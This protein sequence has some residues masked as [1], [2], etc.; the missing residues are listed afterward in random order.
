M[1]FVVEKGV[2]INELNKQ[3]EKEN[4]EQDVGFFESALA[5]VATGLW[6]I[7]K[8]VVSLGAEIFDLVG[9]TNTAKDVE[10]WFDEVNPFDDEA[11]AR[12][13]GKITQALTQ[14]APLAISGAA[15]G[16]RAGVKGAS[17][18]T[19]RAA[20]LR[21]AEF[22]KLT[23]STASIVAKKAIAAKKA[24]KYF[25]LTNAGRKIMGP[26]SGGIVGS[27]V[28]EALVADEDIGTLADIAKGTSF[29]PYALTM[30]DRETKE[31][32]DEAYRKLKNRLKFG[33]EGALFNLA[34]FGA[35][36][37]VQKLRTPAKEGVD[38]YLKT[39]V[40]G[41]FQKIGLG[42][43]AQG[44]GSRKTF[45]L[46]KGSQ[47]SIQ[48]LEIGTMEAIKKIDD[49]AKEVVPAIDDF[50]RQS[51]VNKEVTPFT[52][53][54]FLSKI[55]NILTTKIDPSF[56]GPKTE[57]PSLGSSLLKP[58]SAQKALG[59]IKSRKVIQQSLSEL[60]EVQNKLKLI[61]NE[62]GELNL[63]GKDPY[64]RLL[65]Q[66]RRA[67]LLQD[68]AKLSLREKN[69][70][71]I[72]KE[73]TFLK[74]SVFKIDDYKVSRELQELLDQAKKAGIKNTEPLKNAIL[75]MRMGVD[76]VSS[77]LMQTG[78]LSGDDFKMFS[79]RLGS[80]LN[81][82]YAAFTKMPIF[83]KYKV[84]DE[85]RQKSFD[86]LKA[87]KLKTYAL[88]EKNYYA[89]GPNK[90]QLISPTA[91]QVKGTQ[92]SD[93]FINKQIDDYL[94]KEGLDE[95]NVLNKEFKNGV[96][97]VTGRPATLEERKAVSLNP[98]ILEPKIAEP[99][100]KELIGQIK[101]PKYTFHSTISKQAHLLYGTKYLDD[102]N[103]AWSVGPN[104]KI[105]TADELTK[106]GIDINKLDPRDWKY[107]E[108]GQGRLAGI[109]A[110]DGKYIRAPEYDA[111]FD[112]TSDWLNKTDVGTA[113]R[114]MLLVPK[115]MS[116]ISKTILS[117]ITH[118]RNFI[119]AAS[120]A[121]ANGA[122]LPNLTDI[123]TLAPK[124]FG[125][126]GVLGEAYD[127]TAKRV[128]GTLNKQQ[129]RSYQRLKELGLTGTQVEAGETL[130]LAQDIAEGATGAKAF[131]KL[132]RA[133]KSLKKAYIKAQDTYVAED[134][135]W[136]IVSF[137]LERNR[138]NNIFNKIGFTKDNY[139][140]L[141]NE[142]SNVGRYFRKKVT[143]M[144]IVNESYDGFLDELSA[145]MVRNQ[146]PNYEYIGRTA[147]ALRQSPFGNF[148]A[149]PI[150]IMRTGNNII[151]QSIDEITSG[152][153]QL[154]ALGTRRLLSFG[155]TVGGIPIALTE[156][157][158]AKNN[159]T[160]EEMS[161]LRKF[162][163]E[164]SKNS[165]LLPVGR[166]E[167]G[168]L[169]YVDLSYSTAYDFLLRPYTT[170]VNAIAQTD[171]T[172]ESLKQA[173]GEGLSEGVVEL[174]EPFVSESIFTEALVDSTIRRGIG[175]GGRRVWN[176]QDDPMVKIGKGIFH[177]G[178]ALT[179]G[180]TSQLKRLGL[181][182]TGKTS[183]YGELYNLA[184]E[185]PGLAGFRTINSN[186]ERALTYMST[187]FGRD[188]KKASNL[189]TGPLLRGGRV[190]PDDIVN[191]Y[192][193]SEAQRFQVLKDMYKNIDAA[194]TLGVSESAIRKKVKRK[195]L[196]KNVFNQLMQGK[197]TPSRPNS[198]FVKRMSEITR[199]LNEKEGVN[200]PNPYFES[201]PA[202]NDIISENRNIGLLKDNVSFYE[203]AQEIPQ[204]QSQLP[205]VQA[206]PLRTPMPAPISPVSQQ[207]QSTQANTYASLF[208]R[209]ELGNL[210]AQKK[211]I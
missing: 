203:E 35:G 96:E 78:K 51:S 115:A 114:Y 13:V 26:I 90:G 179:P 72:V 194:R 11:E 34:L 171:G 108:P 155:T 54:K 17:A 209:D 92:Y 180:S 81:D 144:D 127:L 103:K 133:P 24:G 4:K 41:F 106:Q 68:R 39:P 59:Q 137:E 105:F 165:T 104:K 42:L 64:Q 117:P 83:K 29:E 200:L 145:N 9:D 119:S 40:G 202:I 140:T 20:A 169:K 45:E 21:S 61:D 143:R 124:V 22:K 1:A 8:G 2:S 172:E 102:V 79:N 47:D 161:A 175:K 150:E 121:A 46:L 135:F 191:S 138:Y 177:I 153:P 70:N 43:S 184:D 95:A 100:Q 93:E 71:S 116:Q 211:N 76:N 134:D 66:P 36:K 99:W 157:F 136:K 37:G 193:Y 63:M 88:D 128:F 196:S 14:I 94:R 189:F 3:T 162:V 25:S 151:T 173:L 158:K 7:P 97:E 120:F 60:P 176:E 123:Q 53:K 198:F 110:L 62:L 5:G 183:K 149:F 181:A 86:L 159:V 190:D 174:M 50:L 163:P 82:E 129:Q 122:I 111:I 69:L 58:E 84:T 206:P 32:R 6:N 186:P 118:V 164:W 195:G 141:L 132:S 27:G 44:G 142:D 18:L 12:T 65:N 57:V 168:Y 87:D 205:Q 91:E 15:L 156:V 77:L 199:D 170:V 113:Y 101:D 75:E 98:S 48:A 85:I 89:A 10:N 23:G 139:K 112:V 30:L 152:I 192:K 147:K 185:L 67:K 208:P 182:A 38:A 207:T 197:F 56:I 160:E 166:D 33:T 146:V 73:N 210:I 109:S 188:L 125:G 131:D 148:I 178:G 55:Q 130:K 16:A 187:A 19:R 52:E 80:Y 28:G 201:I 126:K 154:K 49:A 204:V 31:G 74:K 167:N 107:V